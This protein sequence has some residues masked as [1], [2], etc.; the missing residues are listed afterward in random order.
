MKKISVLVVDDSPSMRRLLSE[1]VNAAADMEV[2]ATAEDPYEARAKIKQFNPDVLTL[3]VEMPRMDGIAFLGN[4]M[5]LRPMPVIMIS[6]FTEEGAPVTLEALELGAVDFLPKPEANSTKALAWYAAILRE[7]IRAASTVNLAAL[8][9]P[10]SAPGKPAGAPWERAEYDARKVIA[11]GASTGG[12]EAIKTVLLD[13]PPQCPPLMIVQHIPPVFS[14]SYAQRMDRLCAIRVCEAQNGMLL[15]PGCA[16]IAPGNQHLTLEVVAAERRIRLCQTARV[17]RHRPSVD[18]LFRSVLAAVGT[19]AV[20]AL[21]TGMGRDGAQGLQEMRQ[22]GCYTLAQDQLTSV[23][24]GMP[25]AAV[26]LDAVS[27]VCRLDMIATRLLKHCAL[28]QAGK[29]S[30]LSEG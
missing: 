15:E 1:I 19:D 26:A 22:G 24:W 21:L 27:E 23:V 14:A 8:E 4:L 16:Y 10:P 9:T 3:D 11:L 30:T 7:K 18:V 5:R 20:G 28:S 29:T 13:M 6:R 2:V 25:G 12:T 17:N